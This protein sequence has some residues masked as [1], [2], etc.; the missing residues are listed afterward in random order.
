MKRLKNI[1]NKN[2]QQLQAIEDQKEKQLD[3]VNINNISEG[4][5]KIKLSSKN[6][7]A[8][9]L[10]NEVITMIKKNKRKEKICVHSFKWNSVWF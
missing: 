9:D 8:T 7:E 5:K 4:S 10:I 2:E 3:I 6:P 1:E